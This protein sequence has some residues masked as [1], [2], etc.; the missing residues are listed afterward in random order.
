VPTTDQLAALPAALAAATAAAPSPAQMVALID[1]AIAVAVATGDVTVGYTI[2]G[3]SITKS[4]EQARQ[5]REY[6]QLEIARASARATPAQ[7]LTAE[8]P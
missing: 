5:L 6:Y 4:L 3:R 1:A 2:N 7:F 8:M